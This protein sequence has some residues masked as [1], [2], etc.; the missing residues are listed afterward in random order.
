LSAGDRQAGPPAADLYG[1][2]APPCPVESLLAWSVDDADGWLQG[3]LDLAYLGGRRLSLTLGAGQSALLVDD[4]RVLATCGPGTHEL[5]TDSV[6][7][8]PRRL[9][10][11]AALPGPELRWTAESPLRREYGGPDLTGACS[12]GVADPVL[13][14]ETFVAGGGVMDQ[15]FVLV[16]VDRLAQGVID[17][18]APAAD[19]LPRAAD[20]DAA[21]ASSG[22][23][24][25]HLALQATARPGSVP[26]VADKTRPVSA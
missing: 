25:R 8:G 7:A 13:F 26:V 1:A 12:L 24:C 6:V 18:L 20:L 4:D 9:L 3:P 17:S 23:S 10:F 19:A 15:A 11:F 5:A 22:L 16:L 21:L 2:G 14:F